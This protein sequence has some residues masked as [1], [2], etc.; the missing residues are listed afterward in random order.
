[1]W[2]IVFLS[3]GL[4]FVIAGP[5]PIMLLLVFPLFAYEFLGF[6]W[7][8]FYRTPNRIR[9]VDDGLELSFRRRKHRFVPWG[10][11]GKLEV[12]P[13]DPRTFH[14]RYL[15]VARLHV[16]GEKRSFNLNIN[17]GLSIQKA[18]REHIGNPDSFS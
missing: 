1:M 17:S 6:L 16:I 11:I 4:F 12:P 7:D 3:I 9:I 13:A 10:E 14:G 18:L 8:G 15:R 2:A 5:F